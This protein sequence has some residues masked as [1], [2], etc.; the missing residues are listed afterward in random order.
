MKLKTK[1]VKE[2][3]SNII[4]VFFRLYINF[5]YL[6]ITVFLIMGATASILLSYKMFPDTALYLYGPFLLVFNILLAIFKSIFIILFVLAVVYIVLSAV[7]IFE[8][9]EKNYE[10]KRK[11][12]M[13]EIV[14][15]LKKELKNK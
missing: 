4:N 14:S 2:S 5:A 9:K 6:C 12:F 1:K 8:D 11:K 15:K 13:N 10:S 3:I 7:D